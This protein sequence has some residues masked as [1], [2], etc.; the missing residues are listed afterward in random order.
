MIPATS[1]APV[2]SQLR[3]GELRPPRHHHDEL[4]R[5]LVEALRHVLAELVQIATAARAHLA[6]G[7][8]TQVVE[9]LVR[10]RR[11]DQARQPLGLASKIDEL[12]ALGLRKAGLTALKVGGCTTTL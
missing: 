4:R 8:I 7:S 11:A 3:T 12:N 6:L 2:S 9:C 10:L 1:S 5:H